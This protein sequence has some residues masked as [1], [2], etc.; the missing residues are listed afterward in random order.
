MQPSKWISTAVFAATVASNAI[1]AAPTGACGM[2]ETR[3]SFGLDAR[4][5]YDQQIT[6]GFNG[7]ASLNTMMVFDFDNKTYS[8]IWAH[9]NKVGES[10]ASTDEWVKPDGEGVFEIEQRTDVSRVYKITL[11]SDSTKLK[12]G[13]YYNVLPVNG[14]NT[15]LMQQITPSTDTKNRPG[16]NVGVCQKF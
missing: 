13:G 14:G 1:A 3:Q 2:L 5:A 11:Y 10:D 7:K 15:F 8:Y 9:T 4:L 12:S 6:D 16:A